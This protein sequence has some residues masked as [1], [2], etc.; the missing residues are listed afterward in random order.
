MQ[1]R[2]DTTANWAAANPILLDGEIAFEVQKSGEIRVKV[3]DGLTAWNKLPYV[4]FASDG[5]SPI[6]IASASLAA[7][8]AITA[9]LGDATYTALGEG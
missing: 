2:K 6:V 4:P 1:H 8:G 7:N 3:G 9:I 5:E